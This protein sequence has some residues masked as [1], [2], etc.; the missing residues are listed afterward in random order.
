MLSQL[1]RLLQPAPALDPATRAW[2]HAVFEW[3]RNEPD[4]RDRLDRADLVLPIAEHFPGRADSH[5]AMARLVFDSVLR[6]A[7]LVDSSFQL[8]QPGD[9]MDRPVPWQSM[10]TPGVSSAQP[11]AATGPASIPYNPDL[12]TNSQALVAHF[13]REIGLRLSHQ[14]AAPPPAQEGNEYHIAELLAVQLG[15]GVMLANTAFNVRTNQCG[16]CQGPSAERDAALSRD[17]LAYAL[18]LF[19]HRHAIPPARARAHLNAPLRP[20]LRRAHREITRPGTARGLRHQGE[21]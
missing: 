4:W 9:L 18:A 20:A 16:A 11:A 10:G 5:Q 13:A 7:H 17:D 6:H 3:A 19:C 21:A 14:A 12:V 1:A 2:I 15:F 8:A